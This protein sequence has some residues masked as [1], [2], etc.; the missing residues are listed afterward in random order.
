ME[1]LLVRYIITRTQIISLADYLEGD[2]CGAVFIERAFLAWL[3]PM[4]QNVTL[5]PENF[6]TGG[7]STLGKLSNVLL[8]RF[9]SIKTTFDDKP[10]A[11][12]ELPRD[13]KVVEG[14]EDIITGGVVT[15]SK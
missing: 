11:T 9:E 6:G 4:L 10:K 2:E 7:H 13:I 15:L 12:L 3:Q 8:R 1:S 5:L 14:Y